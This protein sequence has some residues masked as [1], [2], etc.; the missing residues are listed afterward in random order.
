MTADDANVPKKFTES[1]Y[2][3]LSVGDVLPRSQ[4]MRTASFTLELTRLVV[5]LY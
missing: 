3:F 5:S 1:V 2:M 4:R